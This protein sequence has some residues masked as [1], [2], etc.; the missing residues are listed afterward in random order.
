MGRTAAV[1]AAT[2]LRLLA[3]PELRPRPAPVPEAR[4]ATATT[5]PAPLNLGL[6]DYLDAHV[7][8]VVTHVRSLP[9]GD[10]APAPRTPGDLYDWYIEHTAH[11]DADE[12]AW[13]D[14]ITERHALEHAIALGEHKAVRPHPCPRCGCWSLF[15]DDAG[16]RARCSIS[17]C[18]TPDGMASSWTLAR[19][20][21]Q[22][23]QR[24]EIWR[25]NA[26]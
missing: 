20:A 14:Y 10:A 13:R 8:E 21:A 12:Q 26:T 1:S 6:I 25:R 18:R 7:T 23:V 24:T 15:W 9:G 2:S 16:T 17:D 11:A 22:K 5:P 4:R 3:S 19:L